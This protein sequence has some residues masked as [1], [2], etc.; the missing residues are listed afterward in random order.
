M[1]AGFYALGLGLPFIAAG[2]AYQRALGALAF[3]RRHQALVMRI[4]GG[5]LVLVGL[6]L[7]TGVWDQAVT[8]L[9]YHVIGSWQVSV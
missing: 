8:W 3:V 7:V 9:Q 2:L 1:L 4:G 6:M 5:L